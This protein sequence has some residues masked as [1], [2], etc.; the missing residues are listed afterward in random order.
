MSHSPVV[1]S[2]LISFLA[3]YRLTSIYVSSHLLDS[4]RLISSPFLTLPHLSCAFFPL[5]FLNLVSSMLYDPLFLLSPCPLLYS[6][7]THTI[8]DGGCG[9]GGCVTKVLLGCW[10]QMWWWWSW[11]SSHCNRVPIWNRFQNHYRLSNLAGNLVYHGSQMGSTEHHRTANLEFF[12]FLLLF[13]GCGCSALIVNALPLY[14]S[15]F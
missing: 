5:P 8:S 13:P 14:R 10:W 11:W 9:G 7:T 12:R 1:S 15:I 3:W 6:L 2:H 4:S